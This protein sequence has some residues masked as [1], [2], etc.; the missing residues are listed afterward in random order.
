[1]IAEKRKLVNELRL[2]S[3]NG[4]SQR[5]KTSS[6]SLSIVAQSIA[7]LRLDPDSSVWSIVCILEFLL[8]HPW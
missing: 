8:R 6:L 3:M 1:M 4:R 2:V 5:N 7:Y